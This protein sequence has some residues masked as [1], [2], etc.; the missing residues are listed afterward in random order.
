MPTGAAPFARYHQVRNMIERDTTTGVRE[1]AE[2]YG[3]TTQNVSLFLSK[4][5]YSLSPLARERRLLRMEAN[6]VKKAWATAERKKRRAP[7][8]TR[9]GYARHR[10]YG[11]KACIPCLDANNEETK[12][13]QRRLA[14]ERK[15]NRKRQSE[16]TKRKRSES[17]LKR[18]RSVTLKALNELDQIKET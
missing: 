4:R 17:L 12:K 5:G 13:I 3:V 11:E 1:V 18:Y 2:H 15:P 16:E 6:A 7:C 14:D 10:Y 9:A 8:G